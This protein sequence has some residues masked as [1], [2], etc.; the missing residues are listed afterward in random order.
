MKLTTATPDKSKEPEQKKAT[1]NTQYLVT[2]YQAQG[3]RRSPNS[4]A[5]G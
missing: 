5:T 4:R 1:Q 3:S 2:L